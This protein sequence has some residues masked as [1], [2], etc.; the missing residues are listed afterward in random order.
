MDELENICNEAVVAYLMPY[1]G[2]YLELE[3]NNENMSRHSVP[4]QIR[5]EHLSNTSLEYF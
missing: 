4:N 1:S 3:N 2:I 5:T